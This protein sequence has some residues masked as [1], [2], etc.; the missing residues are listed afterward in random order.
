M[1][2]YTF[3]KTAVSFMVICLN[4]CPSA[5]LQTH[6]EAVTSDS[7]HENGLWPPD[8]PVNCVNT[9]SIS[10]GQWKMYD[11]ILSL[12][13]NSARIKTTTMKA[14]RHMSASCTKT[15]FA[16][17]VMVL[18]LLTCGDI[19]PCPGPFNYKYPC[20]SCAKPVKRNQRGI[21]C[22]TC[23]C[24]YHCKCIGMDLPTYNRLSNDT[25][26][27]FCDFC[28]TQHLPQLTDSYFDITSDSLSTSNLSD[29]IPSLSAQEDKPQLKDNLY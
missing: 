15:N 26:Q 21:A 13:A 14:S 19:H 23:D 9:R 7:Y 11:T 12:N 29:F 28:Y 5:L 17:K 20:G 1:A 24:W 27:W 25:S 6:I 4:L 2:T 16:Y 18:L 8:F 3:L 10:V 22:D